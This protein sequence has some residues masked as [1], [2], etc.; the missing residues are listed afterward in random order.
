M[1]MSVGKK[2]VMRDQT[3]NGTD[4]RRGTDTATIKKNTKQRAQI[5]QKNA[6]T[7]TTNGGTKIRE[8]SEM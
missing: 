7:T 3:K 1:R 6:E 8:T 5:K 2:M 4:T